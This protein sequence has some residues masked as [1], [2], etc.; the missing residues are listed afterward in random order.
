L[1][2]LGGITTLYIAAAVLVNPWDYF[3][4]Q[5]FR[6]VAL[7]SRKEKL[8]LFESF[9]HTR[10]VE[11]IVFGSSRTMGISPS[12]LQAQT[13]Q[14][15]FNFCVDSARAE[16]YLAIYRWVRSRGIEPKTILIGLDVEA[17]H[18]DDQQD[19][20]LRCNQGLMQ[21]LEGRE[22][23]SFGQAT[24]D[25]LGR[26]KKTLS[27]QYARDMGRSLWGYLQPDGSP[28][29]GAHF[30]ATGAL[31]Y[32]QSKRRAPDDSIGIQSRIAENQE[33]YERRFQGMTALSAKRR[34][35][36]EDLLRETKH[37][38][39]VIWITPIHPELARYLESKTSYGR[40]LGETRQLLYDLGSR[41]G[42]MVYDF[43][44][45]ALFGGD[46]SDWRNGA[47]M[48][49]GNASVL[50]QKITDGMK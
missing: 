8:R 36:L 41:H 19:E 6:P 1:A 49:F 46:E 4:P 35:C 33:E 13:G 38:R 21:A 29:G 31:V 43:S 34:G 14:C 17:L 26:L 2:F 47:Y 44:E 5:V 30:D 25:T 39:R 24:R 11:G 32:G 3:P 12:E 23:G 28:R 10:A 50:T 9:R 37:S 18:N 42:V 48:G 45:P 16:D 20:R 27:D 40:L 15:Y 22:S 7:D